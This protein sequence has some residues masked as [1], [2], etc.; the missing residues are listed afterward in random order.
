M[1]KSHYD[2][3]DRVGDVLDNRVWVLLPG[4]DLPNEP[5]RDEIREADR[6]E[7]ELRIAELCLVSQLSRI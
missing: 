4:I 1:Y 3:E 2:N 6:P 5:R 7:H